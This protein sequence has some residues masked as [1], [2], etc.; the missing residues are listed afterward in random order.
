M[1]YSFLTMSM[2]AELGI[3]VE[4]EE[5]EK[6]D[7]LAYLEKIRYMFCQRSEDY[8]E[9]SAL[10]LY[11]LCVCQGFLQVGYG[12]LGPIIKDMP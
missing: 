7:R 10:P 9:E 3:N 6:A 4:D 5:V 12:G 8:V 1:T 2:A 11:L